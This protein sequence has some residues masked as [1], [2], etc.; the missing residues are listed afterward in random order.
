LLG[1][2]Y[3]KPHALAAGGPDYHGLGTFHA[4]AEGEPIAPLSGAEADAFA[5]SV[6]FARKPHM[7]GLSLAA[8][9]PKEDVHAASIK[10]AVLS[11]CLYQLTAGQ[12]VVTVNG[13]KLDAANVGQELK[14]SPDTVKFAPMH[15]LIVAACTATDTAHRRPLKIIDPT[16]NSSRL[17]KESFE[18]KT[19]EAMRADWLA[20][21]PVL[22]EAK[23]LL[24]EKGKA[25]IP[26]SFRLALAHAEPSDGGV[27]CVRDDVSVRGAV[28]WGKRAAVGLLLAQ[29]NEL[30]GFLGDAEGPS[31]EDWDAEYVKERYSYAPQ[32]IRAMKLALSGLYDTLSSAEADA[33]VENALI[34]FFSWLAPEDAKK[35]KKA[36]PK[37]KPDFPLDIDRK[38]TLVTVAKHKDGFVVSAT[39]DAAQAGAYDLSIRCAYLMRFG[40]AFKEYSEYDFDLEKGH[41]DAHGAATFSIKGNTILAIGAGGELKVRVHGLD[42]NR[43]LDVRVRATAAAQAEAV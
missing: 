14:K 20:G 21:E 1:R 15:K 2:S 38:P 11:E 41:V 24:R 31:H 17:S 42:P 13:E 43:D 6:G 39:A 5:S 10:T 26:A 12:L 9:W 28:Q 7:P 25:P 19:L 32:T 8:L 36:P 35:K 40:D 3:L 30:S 22:I 4:G 18:P 23:T 37:P 27:V 34:N 16:D 29:Q 33:P